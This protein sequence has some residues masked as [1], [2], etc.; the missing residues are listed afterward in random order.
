MDEIP[1]NLPEEKSEK[2]TRGFRDPDVLKRALA[3]SKQS[4]DAKKAAKLTI[5]DNPPDKPVSEYEVPAEVPGLDVYKDCVGPNGE[6]YPTKNMWI[7][8]RV[9]LDPESGDTP[10]HW[11]RIVGVSRSVWYQWKQIA[12]FLEWWKS[13]WDKGIMEFRQDW[14]RIGL[15]RM[16][17]S[18][19][20]A[21]KYW[22]AMGE[23]VF[24]Y[25]QK[26]DLK[27]DKSPEEKALIEE[28]QKIFL[29]QKKLSLARIVDAEATVVE[30]DPIKQLSQSVAEQ[31]DA[32]LKGANET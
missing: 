32:T 22:A 18:G 19:M 21:Y 6:F 17:S 13:E 16:R 5:F 3:K 31:L 20:D 11:M 8:L 2:K 15:R 27:V 25:V 10:A 1:S 4:R 24:G 7:V 9:A 14:I 23:K 26:L 28:L 30:D 12:G 29:S